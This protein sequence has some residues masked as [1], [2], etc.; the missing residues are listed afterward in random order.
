MS[1]T[2]LVTARTR[3]VLRAVAV[4]A[5]LT[6]GVDGMSRT[7]QV[8]GPVFAEF[9]VSVATSPD[10]L[11]V[12]ACPVKDGRCGQGEVNVFERRLSGWVKTDVLPVPEARAQDSFGVSMA[13]DGAT[14]VVGA[15]FADARG[16]DAGLT[17]VFELR[18]GRWQRTAVLFAG[19][20]AAGDE[21]GLTVSVS[22]ETIAVGARLVDSQAVNTGAAYIFARDDGNW[23]QVRK[24]TASDAKAGDIFGR[25][26]IDKDLLLV[27]A[28]L[29]DDRGSNAGKAYAFQNRGGEWVEEA[30]ITASD[31]A[32]VDEFG[33][34]LALKGGVAVFG[35]VGSD[36]Q[37]ED[38]GAA[39]VFERREGRWQAFGYS[40]ATSDDT[41]V[42]GAPNH[43][44]A[45]LRAGAA[46]VFERRGGIWTEAAR[47][48]A[49]DVAPGMWFGNS[50]AIDR[51]RIVVGMLFSGEDKR[52]GSAYV[53]ERG[54]AGWSEVAR[55]HQ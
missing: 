53:F 34:S 17:Y 47:L 5:A 38:S 26:S 7:E 31:G 3:R 55:L 49:S 21:F 48:T 19:D 1:E 13:T 42:V 11:F 40:V 51:N 20:S 28:D 4:L 6:S 25:V 2:V 8:P 18:D 15:Q 12:A 46:Y 36:A 32:A 39:Y 24:L 41:I 29:N 45:G 14:L 16:D 37:S 9:G 23:R 50:V 22:G 44:G 54:A 27:S 35:A 10:T 30:R 33:V 43:G 52:S